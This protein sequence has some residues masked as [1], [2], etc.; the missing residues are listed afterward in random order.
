MARL[1][2]FIAVVVFV[3]GCAH[4]I[5][6][7]ILQKVNSE[8]TFAELQKAAQANREKVVLLGGVI[9][10][11]VNKDTGTLLEVYQTEINH[12]GK[13]IKLD[14]SEGRFL[15]HWKGFLDSE[16]YQKGRKVTI[17]GV[18]KGEEM[19]RLG[20]IDYRCPYLVVK[21][22]HLWEKEQ[23][24]KYMPYPYYP[25]YPWWYP[26]YPY[27]PVYRRLIHSGISHTQAP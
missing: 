16:I 25:W 2:L 23:P 27:H 24:Q 5:S 3:S 12:R 8:V 21:D 15:A 17:V 19:I 1:T 13:P 20:E 9:V 4:V 22:I 6:K 14:I 7:D 10:K 11:T 26:W 18:V